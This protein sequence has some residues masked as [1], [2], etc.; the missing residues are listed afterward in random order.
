MVSLRRLFNPQ[1]GEIR[2]EVTDTHAGFRPELREPHVPA[3]EQGD[4]ALCPYPGGLGLGLAICKAIVEEHHGRIE[5]FS[6]GPG[7]G[8]TVVFNIPTLGAACGR[9]PADPATASRWHARL[10]A[11][12][13][14]RTIGPRWTQ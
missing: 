1:P 14:S 9:R 11:F 13:W 4:D 10:R 5:A 3:F 7:R 6:A 12:C 8:A 2:I